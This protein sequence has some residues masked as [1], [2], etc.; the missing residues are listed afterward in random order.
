[1]RLIKF[2]FISFI[3]YSCAETDRYYS[4]SED[5]YIDSNGK[6]LEQTSYVA[7][8]YKKSDDFL[9]EKLKQELDLDLVYDFVNGYAYATKQIKEDYYIPYY[10]NGVNI[11]G[12]QEWVSGKKGGIINTKGEVIIP[13]SLEEYTEVSDK[14]VRCKIR[15][16]P[17]NNESYYLYGYKNLNDKW[18]L[19]PKYV[20]ADNFRFGYAE[21]SDDFQCFYLINKKGRIVLNNNYSFIY[22]LSKKKLIVSH[23]NTD[24]YLSDLTGKRLSEN[25]YLIK[26]VDKNMC[27]AKNENDQFYINN[28][29]RFFYFDDYK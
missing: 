17:E 19:T 20:Y 21:V 24:F 2:L 14:V 25:F 15:Y 1:M 7:K 26:I 5:L 12:A 23:N 22:V 29:G 9:K 8:K 4:V 3:F 28:K 11:E 27:L 6:Q 10:E 13:F 16:F 18:I